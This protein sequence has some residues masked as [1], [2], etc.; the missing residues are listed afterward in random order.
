MTACAQ[1]EKEGISGHKYARGWRSNDNVENNDNIDIKM[2]QKS[3]FSLLVVF[4]GHMKLE[5]EPLRVSKDGNLVE[6]FP[7]DWRSERR[8]LSVMEAEA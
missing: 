3:F 7:F 8:I 5:F 4:K 2:I 1:S 6:I